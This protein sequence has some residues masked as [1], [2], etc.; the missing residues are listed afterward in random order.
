MNIA[1]LHDFLTLVKLSQG[2]YSLSGNVPLLRQAVQNYAHKHRLELCTKLRSC[3]SSIC[4]QQEEG[5]KGV[6]MILCS[7]NIVMSWARRLANQQEATVTV[8]IDMATAKSHE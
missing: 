6:S 4:Q 7:S 1:V 8:I 2:E 3:E 5:T